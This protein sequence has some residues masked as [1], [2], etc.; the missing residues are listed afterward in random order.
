MQR[1]RPYAPAQQMKKFDKIK[2]KFVMKVSAKL[3]I[4]ENFLILNEGCSEFNIIH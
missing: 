2:Y 1:K 4:K 3:G